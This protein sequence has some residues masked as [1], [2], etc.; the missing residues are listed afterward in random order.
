MT[1]ASGVVVGV[2]GSTTAAVGLVTA[3][4]EAA[5][6]GGGVTAVLAYPAPGSWADGDGVADV[7]DRRRMASAVLEQ[8]RRYVDEATIPLSEALR[9]VPLEV[10][11]HAGSPAAVLAGVARGAELLVVG[12]RGRGMLGRAVLG[13][14]SLRVLALAPCPVLV[15]RPGP[16]AADGPVVVGIDRSENSAAALRYALADAGRRGVG[17]VAVTGAA[18]PPATVGFRPLPAA[19]LAEV[20]AG[21]EPRIE[22]FVR[23]IVG[24]DRSC[25]PVP[26][27]EVVVRAED[28]T[29]AVVEVAERYGAPVVV[30]GRTGR[31]ALE[32]W[33]L[34]SVA[35]GTVL[36]APCPVVVVP[37]TGP[38]HAAIEGDRDD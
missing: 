18:P 33:L 10:R 20:R 24:A 25:P 21:L 2:D 1:P 17:V 8:A 11:V 27:V 26:A 28:P 13:S 29:A 16:A 6:R 30:V 7:P 3:I 22:Q 14:T 23:E 15:V 35:H 12:H 4:E 34:G 36:R 37:D 38:Y 32:R 9:A 19:T 5:R 31:G